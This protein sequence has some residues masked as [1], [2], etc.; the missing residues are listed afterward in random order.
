MCPKFGL[1]WSSAS[2]SCKCSPA[3]VS[4]LYSHL[5]DGTICQSVHSTIR[6]GPITTKLSVLILHL[7]D[8]ISHNISFSHGHMFKRAHRFKKGSHSATRTLPKQETTVPTSTS[9]S[10]PH[11]YTWALCP[12]SV[13]HVTLVFH[14][15][16]SPDSPH[17]SHTIPT[18]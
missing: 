12:M 10:I 15:P 8:L 16:P 6:N 11:P 14:H 9:A 5:A 13:T 7:L 17:H 3:P 1:D 18:C 2:T 4:L